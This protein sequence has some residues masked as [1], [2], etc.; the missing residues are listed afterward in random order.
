MES[1]NENNK[2]I[3]IIKNQK[4]IIHKQQDEIES[5]KRSIENWKEATARLRSKIVNIKNK[6]DDIQIKVDMN[7]KKDDIYY[8]VKTKYDASVDHKIVKYLYSQI[9]D[10]KELVI[11]EHP[12]LKGL[13]IDTSSIS[14]KGI[15]NRNNYWY[16]E[17]KEVEGFKAWPEKK[18]GY[19][20]SD[21]KLNDDYFI[22]SDILKIEE[23]VKSLKVG[24][25]E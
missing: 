19:I 14:I 1:L 2:L 7:N 10:K 6:G 4:S 9:E 23:L 22:R 5:L 20:Y 8:R 17:I 21:K 24:N 16:V 12:E 18:E 11:K 15:F 25:E 13:L 3:Q